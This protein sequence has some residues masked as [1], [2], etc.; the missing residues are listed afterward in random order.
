MYGTVATRNPDGTFGPA[1][2]IGQA[3]N[4]APN[5][6]GSLARL[7]VEIMQDE[8]AGEEKEKIGTED[9]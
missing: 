5:V 6:L 7:L 8:A 3:T 4:L 1:R 2:Q 9:R